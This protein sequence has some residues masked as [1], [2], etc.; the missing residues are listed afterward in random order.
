[1][2]EENPYPRFKFTDYIDSH[3]TKST[4]NFVEIEATKNDLSSRRIKIPTA[5][6]KVLIAGRGMAIK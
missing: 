5:I 4:F 3:L 1:M 6:P 2:Y